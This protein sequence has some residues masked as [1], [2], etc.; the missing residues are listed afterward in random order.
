MASARHHAAD[1]HGDADVN[2]DGQEGG[3][4]HRQVRH[5]PPGK[6]AMRSLQHLH[7]LP[8]HY[9]PARKSHCFGQRPRIG[10]R[11]PRPRLRPAARQLAHRAVSPQVAGHEPDERA[12]ETVPGSRFGTRV[13]RAPNLGGIESSGGSDAR[14]QGASLAR[15]FLAREF[16]AVLAAGDVAVEIT[17]H[18]AAQDDE[19]HRGVTEPDETGETPAGVHGHDKR[20]RKTHPDVQLEPR[21]AGSR[22]RIG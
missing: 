7:L 5:M 22:L 12:S 14:E 15:H 9:F 6:D 19:R 3:D 18:D 16:E 1:Q 2:E 13:K 20:Q 17:P 21:G 11:K 10:R 4:R 8:Q